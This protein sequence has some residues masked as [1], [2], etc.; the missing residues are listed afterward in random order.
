MPRRVQKSE[1][2]SRR[3][4]TGCQPC[5]RRKIKCD[6]KKPTCSQCR[7]KGLCCDTATSL[8]WETD[9]HSRGLAFGRAGVW[10]KA[11]GEDNRTTSPRPPQPSHHCHWLPIPLVKPYNFLNTTIGP[12]QRVDVLDHE[13]SWD[14][15]LSDDS[16]KDRASDDASDI[17]SSSSSLWLRETQ[18]TSLPDLIA[19]S[20][21]PMPQLHL[22]TEKRLLSYFFERVCPLTVSQ[23]ISAPP[24]AT[25]IFPYSVSQSPIV[26]QALL[27][28]AACHRSRSDKIYQPIALSMSDKVVRCLRSRIATESLE[29]IVLDPEPLVLMMILC[30]FEIVYQSEKGWV[31]H[32]KG[33]RDLIRLRRRFQVTTGILP[34]T[35]AP[36]ACAEKFFA[37]QDVVGRT[38]CGETPIFGSDF[39]TTDS[40]QCDTW[41]GCSPQLVSIL[42][43]ITELS[44]RRSVDPSIDQ[45]FE[46][47]FQAASL[48]RQ[49]DHLQQ[50][51]PS[52]DDLLARSAALK[53]DCVQLY[54]HCSLYGATPAMPLV[55]DRVCD[56]LRMT[57]TLLQAGVT[58]GLTWPLFLAAVELSP[59]DESMF[60]TDNGIEEYSRPFIL[61]S[62][63]DL[64]DSM[65]NVRRTR[66]VIEK[67]WAV[68][69][70]HDFDLVENNHADQHNDWERFVAPFCAQMSLA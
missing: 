9:Y 24:L 50:N 66:S 5:R 33:A 64:S 13:C 41:L 37:F 4:R 68:R 70:A 34:E 7:L 49:L 53:R 55:K 47:Q 69:E 29:E 16:E 54:L 14:L 56:I 3:T 17:V 60:L 45:S 57:S 30:L 51:T 28:L 67:V 63:D 11:M 36:V 31:V 38:A 18:A 6:E 19:S 26:L 21:D 1:P 43:S 58:S 15:I 32:L 10:L 48:E 62:L 52:E 8:K 12:D 40:T 20:L 23:S 35:S 61:R 59:W 25:I 46:Y 2:R 65:S 42:C 27:A 44:R 22:S 39:W